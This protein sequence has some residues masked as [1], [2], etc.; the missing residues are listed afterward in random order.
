MT[1]TFEGV[2]CDIREVK[3]NYL[4]SIASQRFSPPCVCISNETSMAEEQESLLN[5]S[6]LL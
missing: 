4:I 1:D 2:R 3:S 5:E 6:C